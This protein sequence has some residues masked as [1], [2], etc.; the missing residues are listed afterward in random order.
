MQ[1]F[2]ILTTTIFEI[3]LYKKEKKIINISIIKGSDLL[4]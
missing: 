2:F 4:W 1:H 3:Q